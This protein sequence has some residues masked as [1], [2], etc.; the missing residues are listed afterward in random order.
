MTDG[1]MLFADRAAFRAWLTAH[2]EDAGIWLVFSKNKKLKT[3]SAAQA[4][5]EA[6]CFG[7]I[8][9]QMESLDSDR[10]I[11]Y[12]S[13]RRA[14][15]KWSAKNRKLAEQLE[16]DG[17]MTECGRRKIRE[18]QANGTYETAPRS[19]VTDEQV[20]EL[21]GLLRPYEK[22]LANFEKMPP[23]VRRTYAG[24]YF[25][26]RTEAGRTKKLTQLAERLE[27]N[28]DP[29]ASLAKKKAELGL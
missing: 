1:P 27:L 11:K 20:A 19:A 10:Y 25:S 8:D 2:A 26:V 4:L 29:M 14:N 22:A 13:P 3:L 9:G 5:E 21:T 17:K 24:A 28:L 18:A 7:W 15:S 16:A 6:L 12:F 23:S